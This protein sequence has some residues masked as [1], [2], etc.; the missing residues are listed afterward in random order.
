MSRSDLL[1]TFIA[2]L[3][4]EK[5]SR[6]P[7]L[8]FEEKKREGSKIERFSHAFPPFFCI[9]PRFYNSMRIIIMRVICQIACR[10]VWP[11]EVLDFLLHFNRELLTTRALHAHVSSH[12][13]IDTVKAILRKK[14]LR[15]S[16]S[17]SANSFPSFPGACVLGNTVVGQ[18]KAAVLSLTLLGFTIDFSFF[19]LHFIYYIILT[20]VHATLIVDF[21]RSI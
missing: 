9:F 18:T 8:V 19:E 15:N 21:L 10:L 14:A 16:I 12:C 20:V 1:L 4:F 13:T 17:R 11:P 2:L 5:L 6:I 3:Q 7:Y